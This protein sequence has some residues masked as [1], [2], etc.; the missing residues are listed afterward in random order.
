ML[1]PKKVELQLKIHCVSSYSPD[2]T[3]T[4]GLKGFGHVE[5]VARDFWRLTRF[6]EI[7]STT[8]I[9]RMILRPGVALESLPH[10]LPLSGSTALSVVPGRA[11]LCLRYRRSSHVRKNCVVPKCDVCHNFG[12]LKE[13]C[14]RTYA[15]TI[16][17][18]TADPASELLMDEGEAGATSKASQR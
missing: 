4:A 10:Q 14:V 11:P 7:E 2:D 16:V 8:R 18:A 12:H 5:E 3:S 15:T 6:E 17:G 1:D 13:D 9:V